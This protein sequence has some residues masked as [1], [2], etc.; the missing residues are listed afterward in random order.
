[1]K[2]NFRLNGL[3]VCFTVIEFLGASAIGQTNLLVNGNFSLGNTGFTSQYTYS[4]GNLDPASVYDVASNPQAVN[5]GWASFGD[6]TT[7]TGLML[8]VNGAATPAI[9]WS[10]TI[11]VATNTIYALSGWATDPDAGTDPAPP[12]LVF[13]VNGIQLGNNVQIPSSNVG[14]QSFTALWNS[15]SST[16]AVIQVVDLNTIAFG[17]DFCLDDLSFAALSTNST[18]SASI[19]RSVEINWNSKSNIT[20]QVQWTSSLPATNWFNLGNPVAA[21]GTNTSVWDRVGWGQRFYQILNF[22]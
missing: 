4:P 1:M 7:G 6:H 21:V 20:Y 13:S 17:N 10:E 16:Q 8:I 14:W 9:V 2:F 5:N 3:L 19:Y 15:Q 18:T 12:Q 22:Q 11:N